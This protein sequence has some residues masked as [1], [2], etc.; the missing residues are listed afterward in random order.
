MTGRIIKTKRGELMKY[1][2]LSLDGGGIRGVFTARLIERLQVMYPNLLSGVDLIA[3]TSTG[4]ILALGLASGF[5]AQAMKQLYIN[6][7]ATI[8]DDSWLDNLRDLGGLS[9]A[10][11]SC[12]G[13]AKI[14]QQTFGTATLGSLAK[15][16]LIPTFDL[17]K[18]VG[19]TQFQRKT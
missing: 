15:R 10:Q 2:I 4:G 19:P 11:Y 7:A 8:F 14:T 5:S 6:N 13:L 17:D 12:D 3:G 16:V 18:S 1:R 9:G